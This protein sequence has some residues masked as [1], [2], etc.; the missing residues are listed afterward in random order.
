M[1]LLK[2]CPHDAY[3]RVS[4]DQCQLHA[5]CDMEKHGLLWEEGIVFS[6]A[7]QVQQQNNLIIGNS[8]SVHFLGS[9]EPISCGILLQ[10]KLG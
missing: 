7:T 2:S 4:V 9:K 8:L 5:C 6:P 1:M 3:R 10:L